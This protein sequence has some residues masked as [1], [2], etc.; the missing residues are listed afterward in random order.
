MS[1]SHHALPACTLEYAKRPGDNESRRCE[2]RADT[3]ARQKEEHP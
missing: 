3:N 2:R 1:D